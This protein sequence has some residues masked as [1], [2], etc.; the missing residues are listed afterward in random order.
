[1]FRSNRFIY[2]QLINDETGQTLVS[3]DSRKVH[4]KG[5][6]AQAKE[7]GKKI[8]EEAHKKGITQ[9]IFDRGGFQYQGMIAA[10]AEGA[11]E[12]GLS[13]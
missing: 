5:G 11:R 7:V 3:A 13:F 4:A 12:A 2:G 9:V 8:G 6:Q 1:V 10:L